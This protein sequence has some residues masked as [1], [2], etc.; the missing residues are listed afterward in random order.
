MGA[1]ELDPTRP[2]EERPDPEAPVRLRQAGALAAELRSRADVVTEILLP[3]ATLLARC[4]PEPARQLLSDLDE[5]ARL[6]PLAPGV[7]RLRGAV[8][9]EIER[10]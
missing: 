5:V 10:A 7:E 9:A 6:H 2:G 3:A 8:A 4:A 1:G